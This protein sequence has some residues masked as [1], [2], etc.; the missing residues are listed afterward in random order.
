MSGISAEK[1]KQLEGTRQK[2]YNEHPGLER[3][4]K[5]PFWRTTVTVGDTDT[6]TLLVY[7]GDYSEELRRV[8]ITEKGE[9]LIISWAG[10]DQK[11]SEDPSVGG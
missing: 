2:Y 10:S 9:V 1:L 3:L 8:F 11:V 7:V 4:S 5:K 6:D